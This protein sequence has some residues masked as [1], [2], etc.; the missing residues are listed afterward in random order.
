V[1]FVWYSA[2]PLM[3]Q[4]RSACLLCR[5]KSDEKAL[6]RGDSACRVEPRCEKSTLI[7][8]ASRNSNDRSIKVCLYNYPLGSKANYM[9]AGSLFKRPVWGGY[10]W[11]RGL[12]LTIYALPP[13]PI[14]VSGLVRYSCGKLLTTIPM[15]LD[16]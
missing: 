11:T 8:K 6:L 1:H 9:Y 5:S 7:H 10:K 13:P 3:D 12:C 4:G 2:S 15:S 16:G 14:Q